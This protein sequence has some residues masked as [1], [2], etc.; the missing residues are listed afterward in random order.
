MQN[1]PTLREQTDTIINNIIFSPQPFT[2][3]GDVA[4]VK[5]LL[6]T[7]YPVIKSY[8]LRISA[9][10]SSLIE[11]LHAEKAT[12][13]MKLWYRLIFKAMQSTMPNGGFYYNELHKLGEKL[14]ISPDEFLAAGEWGNPKSHL[15]LAVQARSSFAI[16]PPGGEYSLANHVCYWF[17][18]QSVV[19]WFFRE[20]LIKSVDKMRDSTSPFIF[21]DGETLIFLPRINP[22]IPLDTLLAM[23][24]LKDAN[25]KKHFLLEVELNCKAWATWFKLRA[26]AIAEMAEKTHEH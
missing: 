7:I 25:L 22:D 5:G 21:N 6:L 3:T 12:D 16:N 24:A 11:S 23:E 13:D 17:V 10:M 1:Q 19:T 9:G 2:I 20:L 4:Y 8:N 15:N 18:M 14:S 26:V